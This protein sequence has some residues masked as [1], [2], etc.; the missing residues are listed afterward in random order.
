[1]ALTADALTTW[2]T[3]QVRLDLAD[4]QQADAEALINLA[5]K[6]ANQYTHRRL[7]ARDRTVTLSGRGEALLRLPDYPINDITAVYIDGSREFDAQTEV[8]D[9]VRDDESGT[10]WRDAGWTRGGRNIRIVANLGYDEIPVDLE[11]SVV[12]LV[13]YWLDSPRIAYLNPQEPAAGGGYHAN[14]VGVMDLP[15]QVR[16]I[17]DMYREVGF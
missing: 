12:Q 8:D 5:S 15:Y 6:R 1:M 7:R 10:L 9:Y 3:V 2:E 13:A 17:W 4:E 16:S 11:E 14:Y